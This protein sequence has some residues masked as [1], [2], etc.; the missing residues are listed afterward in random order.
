MNNMVMSTKNTTDKRKKAGIVSSALTILIG[1]FVVAF[2]IYANEHTYSDSVIL[3]LL[4][5]LFFIGDGIIMIA[6]HCVNGS[7]YLDVYKDRFVGK[8]IQNL[9]ALN[10]NIKI[11][12]INN[13]SIE[14]V[15]LHIQTSSGTYK[16]MTDKNTATNVFNYY[17]ELK[18]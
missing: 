2:Y 8:G 13:I 14:G 18:G 7:T 9:N 16:V 17:I 1:I 15:W 5:G 3:I 6:I 12:D 10:F 4:L 11:E